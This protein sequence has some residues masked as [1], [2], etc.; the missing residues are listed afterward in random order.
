[1]IIIK[2]AQDL[3]TTIQRLKAEGFTIH[4]VPTM[5]ALHQGHLSLLEKA[6]APSAKVV[7]SIFV[8]PTQFNNA[9]DFEKY[10]NTLESD[11]YQLDNAE[12]DILFLPS[13][14]EMYP[15]GTGRSKNY[16]LGYLE[17][18]LEG[19]FRPGHFQ[20]VC[21][22]V[23]RLLN[24]VKP[25]TLLIGQKDYQQCMVLKKMVSDLGMPVKIE[26]GK[27][28]REP[29]GLAM[30]SR[31]MRLSETEREQAT[32]IYRTLLGMKKQLQ[33]GDI[34]HIKEQ[35]IQHLRNNGFK[36]EYTE[37]ADAGNL[38]L[39]DEWDG[40]RKLVILAAAFLGDV[41]LIDNILV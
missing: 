15:Q 40:Q 4:F 25:D 23:E 33:A 17:T 38:A 19:S 11:I 41:R 39:V 37:I 13:V 18:I 12:V 27:T 6:K 32:E 30:S 26:I 29:S 8:N 2:T 24:L 34:R 16:N 5:G 36:P 21:Q 1:M 14:Q 3:T 35:A 31:N 9:A 28:L 20:G 10:P 22:V 7:A